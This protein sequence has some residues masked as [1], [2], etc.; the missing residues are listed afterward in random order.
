VAEVAE[1]AGAT[2]GEGPHVDREPV[3]AGSFADEGAEG[4]AGAQVRVG[5]PWPGYRQMTAADVRDRL[6]VATPEALA[7][8]RLYEAAHRGRR[9][10]LDE[11]DRRLR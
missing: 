7:A 4:G 8:V 2:I 1:A 6:A 5:E 11:V 3:L 9:T 10:I